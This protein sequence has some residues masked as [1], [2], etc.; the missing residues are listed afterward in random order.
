MKISPKDANPKQTIALLGG[1][2]DPPHLG[3]LAVAQ[4]AHD[5]LGVDEVWLLVTPQ[6][7]EKPHEAT[8]FKHRIW[9]CQA[10]A[11]H[12][13]WL[14]VS[15]FEEGVGSPNTHDV[16]SKLLPQHPN[17]QFIWLMGA[18]NL[19]SIHTWNGWDAV[20][21][22]MTPLVIYNRPEHSSLL[23]NSHLLHK[24]TNHQVPPNAPFGAPPE[25]RV[26]EGFTHT[27]TSTEIRHLIKADGTAVD[28]V[29]AV[30]N[31]IQ[32]QGLYKTP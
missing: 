16:L 26:I 25:W 8:L 7:P 30:A 11:E 5:V 28:T 9:M 18:D 12:H 15:D 31:Y 14:K 13:D 24:Y 3:H 29:D 6:N 10:L 17:T 23:K 22:K 27:A 19:A 21:Q 32:K 1:S 20:M 4:H 2:F